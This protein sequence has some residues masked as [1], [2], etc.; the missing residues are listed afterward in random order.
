MP[1]ASEIRERERERREAEGRR[2]RGWR[3]GDV[4]VGD[5]GGRREW[6]GTSES[7]LLVAI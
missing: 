2:R 7:P 6:R 5:G 4:G 1:C 3:G